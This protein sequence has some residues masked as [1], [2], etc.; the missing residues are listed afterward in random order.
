M[1]TQDSAEV[2]TEVVAAFWKGKSYHL[3]AVCTHDVTLPC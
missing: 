3:V 1:G 2:V